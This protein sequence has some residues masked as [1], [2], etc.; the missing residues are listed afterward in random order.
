MNVNANELLPVMVGKTLIF[1]KEHLLKDEIVTYAP[2]DGYLNELL[3]FI[4]P[5]ITQCGEHILYEVLRLT[6][7]ALDRYAAV[8]SGIAVLGAR[9]LE[10]YDLM[11]KHYGVINT[12]AQKGV[13][14]LSDKARAEFNAIYG[15]DIAQEGILGGFEFLQRYDYFNERSLNVLWEAQ[16]NQKLASGTYCQKVKIFE[17]EIF[18][19]NGFHPYQL[20]HYTKQGA[21]IIVFNLQS[22]TDWK[23]LRKDM[24]GETDPRKANAGS[25]RRILLERKNQWGIP[26]I[27]QANNGV[28]LSAGPVEALAETIRFCSDYAGQKELLVGCTAIGRYMLEKGIP[29]RE[30]VRLIQNPLVYADGRQ[31]KVFDLTEEINFS[32]CVELLGKL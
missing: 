12:I 22:N 11:S 26:E 20:F 27:S 17:E 16:N 1:Q 2:K 7:T 10:K 28:H 18:L 32:E 8:V 30:I 6:L 9:Y 24:I 21:S 29:E 3:F 4:K 25:I 19:L 15:K 13:S 5:E 31:V 23:V 14:A